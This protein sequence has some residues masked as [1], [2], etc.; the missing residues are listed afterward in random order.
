MVAT[1]TWY[2]M[3]AA[4]RMI[5]VE[6]GPA[7]YPATSASPSRRRWMDGH[8]RGIDGSARGANDGDVESGHR[9]ESRM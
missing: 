7:P 1:N 9:Q 3:R 2:A 5:D 4:E 8:R 6:W